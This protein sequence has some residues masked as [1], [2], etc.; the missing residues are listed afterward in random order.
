[1]SLLN[2]SDT[3]HGPWPACGA[4][5]NKSGHATQPLR[6]SSNVV[7]TQHLSQA[8]MSLSAETSCRSRPRLKLL[9]SRR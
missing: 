1:M 4:Q 8:P 7:D 2:I 5:I 9:S 6:L 3:I